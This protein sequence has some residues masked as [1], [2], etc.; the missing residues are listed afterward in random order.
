MKSSGDSAFATCS[1][2]TG[3]SKETIGKPEM[4][5]CINGKLEDK[6]S[7]HPT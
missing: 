4:N 6:Y 3:F 7:S 1:V 2:S 5:T